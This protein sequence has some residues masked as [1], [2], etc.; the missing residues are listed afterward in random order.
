MYT[1]AFLITVE[2]RKF[3][4]RSMFLYR[5][6]TTFRYPVT[7]L[8]F[9]SKISGYSIHTMCAGTFRLQFW[10]NKYFRKKEHLI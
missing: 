4:K 6:K 1:C 10:N 3:W 5:L 9:M 7:K 8:K 2:T